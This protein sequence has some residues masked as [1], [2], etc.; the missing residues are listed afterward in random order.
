MS[1][2][3]KIE[4]EIQNGQFIIRLD[5][6]IVA[7]TQNAYIVKAFIDIIKAT[8]KKLGAESTIK[9]EDIL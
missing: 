6:D 7:R 2:S 1:K 9:G 8:V 4:I 3:L 5:G